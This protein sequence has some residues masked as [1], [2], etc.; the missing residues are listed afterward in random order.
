MCG[1]PGTR[2]LFKLENM[3]QPVPPYMTVL[4]SQEQH[5]KTALNK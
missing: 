4:V 5:L 2:S 3:R 1:C